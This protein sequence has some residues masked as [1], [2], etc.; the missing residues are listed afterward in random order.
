MM[1][2]GKE[3]K[4]TQQKLYIFNDILFLHYIVLYIVYTNSGLS[5]GIIIIINEIYLK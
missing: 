1:C 4:N 5:Y 2:S 3:K